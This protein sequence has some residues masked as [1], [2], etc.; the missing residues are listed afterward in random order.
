MI[1]PIDKRNKSGVY[2][3]PYNSRSKTYSYV[4]M[5]SRKLRERIKEHKADIKKANCPLLFPD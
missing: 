4:G 3:I 5:T 1:D 2:I